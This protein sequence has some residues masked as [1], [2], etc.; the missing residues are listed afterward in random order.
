MR[1]IGHGRTSTLRAQRQAPA[2]RGLWFRRCMPAWKSLASTE[3]PPG[4]CWAMATRR[5]PPQPV[6]ATN[7]FSRGRGKHMGKHFWAA[8]ATVLAF[9]ATP[10]TSQTTAPLRA[11]NI[12]PD[13]YP[14]TEAMKSFAAEV[15]AGTQ[16]RHQIQ[17]FSDAVLGDQSKA[18]Q[19]LKAGEIDVAEF[20]LGPLAEA[21]PPL[22]AFNLPL[23]V[24]QRHAHVPLPGR[25]DG[26]AARGK[27]QGVRLR[28][29]GLV[30]RRRPLVLLRRQAHHPPRGP[31]GAAHP[32][33]A[34]RFAH[35]DGEAAGRHAGGRALQGSA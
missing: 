16:G 9:W 33:A 11:W 26:R 3:E 24:Q 12:H 2:R 19:M 35:R 28:R 32:R 18:V 8:F 6:W 25:P 20:N 17:I 27:A 15:Q 22:Q 34:G 23:P 7:Q 13:G 21:V 30:Q 10:A 4:E 5:L 14:V 1:P 31:G 29:A